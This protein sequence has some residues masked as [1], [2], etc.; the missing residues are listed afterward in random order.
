MLAHLGFVAV[1]TRLLPLLVVIMAWSV[2]VGL[3]A[4]SRSRSSLPGAAVL[5]ALLPGF[6]PL[7]IAVRGRARRAPATASPSGGAPVPAPAGPVAMALPATNCW[8]GEVAG[9]TSIPTATAAPSGGGWFGGDVQQPAPMPFAA[10][11]PTAPE[12]EPPTRHRVPLPV[13][14]AVAVPA[15]LLLWTL[16]CSWASLD[17]PVPVTAPLVGAL[18]VTAIPDV[19]CAVALGVAGS[20]M[21]WRPAGRWAVLAASAASACLLTGLAVRALLD[22]SGVVL[23]LVRRAAGFNRV[24]VHEAVSIGDAVPLVLTAGALGLLW[25]F[26]ALLML[27]ARRRAS[28]AGR[29]A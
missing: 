14:A 9:P 27:D 18:P 22:V 26:V 20:L 25:A 10:S 4:A 12:T 2:V 5:S 6:G 7:F 17:G 11:A 19:A 15:V 24:P 1:V 23:R 28:S 16:G 8:F 3:A 13:C 21:A 29:T